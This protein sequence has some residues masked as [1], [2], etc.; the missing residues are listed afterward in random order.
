[1]YPKDAMVHPAVRKEDDGID[2]KEELPTPN[3][4]APAAKKKAPAK[5]KKAG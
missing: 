5:K 1:M 2:L 3:K 4:K